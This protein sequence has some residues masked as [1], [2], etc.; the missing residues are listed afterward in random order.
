MSGTG[1][2]LDGGLGPAARLAAEAILAR[3]ADVVLLQVRAAGPLTA[4]RY[5]SL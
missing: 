5:K 4:L 2:I 1:Y 3:G